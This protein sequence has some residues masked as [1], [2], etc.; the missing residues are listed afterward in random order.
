MK[1]ISKYLEERQNANDY[2]QGQRDIER[3]YTLH[4]SDYKNT[5]PCC[6][7]IRSV[8]ETQNGICDSCGF[9]KSVGA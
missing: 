2:W 5:C 7:M 6:Y 8:L 3:S 9:V 4:G 1:T